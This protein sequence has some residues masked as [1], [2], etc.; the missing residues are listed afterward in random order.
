VIA[1]IKARE[2]PHQ[3][4]ILFHSFS[5]LTSTTDLQGIIH[6]AV[7]AINFSGKVR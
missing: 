5:K 3:P 4:V 1:F 7:E 6:L 2:N